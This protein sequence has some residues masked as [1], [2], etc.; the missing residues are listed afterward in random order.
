VKMPSQAGRRVF[1]PLATKQAPTASGCRSACS[2]FLLRDSTH[3][4]VLLEEGPSLMCSLDLHQLCEELSFVCKV[5]PRYLG[6]GLQ[7]LTL[8]VHD[9]S[10]HT[11]QRL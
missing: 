3:T 5:T 10:P 2:H 4:A 7:H 1:S 6:L 11:L 8:R 9:V